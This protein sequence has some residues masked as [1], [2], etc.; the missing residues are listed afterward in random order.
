[1]T[2]DGMPRHLDQSGY[3]VADIRKTS[4]Q[5]QMNLF[6]HQTMLPIL[7]QP[8]ADISHGVVPGMINH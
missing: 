7:L 8:G 6:Q 2:S 3:V 4:N 1:M 5:L